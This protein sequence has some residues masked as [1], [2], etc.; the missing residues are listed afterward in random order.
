MTEPDEIAGVPFGERRIGGKPET[1]VRLAAP[2]VSAAQ[3]AVRGK[4]ERGGARKEVL[5]P[6]HCCLAPRAV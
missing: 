3:R 6:P 4:V 2:P 1:V 5:L